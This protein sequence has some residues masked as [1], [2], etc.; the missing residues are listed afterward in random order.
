[1]SEEPLPPYTYTPGVTPHP[2]SDPAGHSHGRSETAVTVNAERLSQSPAF[3]RGN[4]VTS[5]RFSRR[6]TGAEQVAQA[7]TVEASEE[8]IAAAA[9]ARRAIDAIYATVEENKEYLGRIDAIAGDGD[10]GIG[11]SRGSKAAAE[12]AN[13]TDGVARRRQ[14][15]LDPAI[16][17]RRPWRQP[18]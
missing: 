10:H 15:G 3:R 9:F 13:E 6:R 1:M 4:A 7:E 12:A 5:E 18:R 11:M 2:I 8:S 14:H 17:R 16:T